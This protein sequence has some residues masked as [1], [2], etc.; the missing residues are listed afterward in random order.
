LPENQEIRDA[1]TASFKR[2]GRLAERSVMR[3]YGAVEHWAKI[4]VP[5]SAEG[6]EEMR[7]RLAARYPLQAFAQARKRLDPKN[8]LG[9]T[10]VDTVLSVE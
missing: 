4:E 5:E 1:V 6:L 7:A 3:K 9:N 2:Y 8:I 10:L